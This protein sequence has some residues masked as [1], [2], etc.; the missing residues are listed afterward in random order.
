MG[1]R[2]LVIPDVHGSLNWRAAM[3]YVNQFNEIISLGDW[4]DSFENNW[5]EVDQI[6]NLKEFIAFKNIYKDK[7]IL[8]LGN[9]DFHYVCGM[10]S[11]RYSG[12]QLHKM[13]DIYEFLR[14]VWNEFKI[15]HNI[16]NVY[17][18]H[19]GVSKK[20]A[21]LYCL[22]NENDINSLWMEHQVQPFGFTGHGFDNHGD[23]FTQTPI[24]I[25]PLS[26]LGGVKYTNMFFNKQV[27]G[28]TAI[29]EYPWLFQEHPNEQL[30]LCDNRN[31][32][33]IDVTIDDGVIKEYK[34]FTIE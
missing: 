28:H 22:N 12:F 18:S 8:L 4:F 19:A 5:D 7:V 6:N 16:D 11:E 25:R 31:H 29:P 3:A 24:W 17:F 30:L 26:L 33:L 14:S 13:F 10:R 20:W 15:V 34:K 23:D 32:D 27:V 9:H 2:I 1:K 21:E